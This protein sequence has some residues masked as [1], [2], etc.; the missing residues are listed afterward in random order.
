[1]DSGIRC[2]RRLFFERPIRVTAFERFQPLL[3]IG[4]WRRDR[5]KQHAARDENGES[6]H[7]ADPYRRRQEC[8]QLREGG[9]SMSRRRQVCRVR[10]SLPVYPDALNSDRL[11]AGNVALR[12]VADV[13]RLLRR[14]SQPMQE[15]L[16]CFRRRLAFAGLTA[17][18]NR[19][20]KSRAFGF[21]R[22]KRIP[23]VA[24]HGHGDPAFA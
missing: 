17:H 24:Q 10:L 3:V 5:R 16:E 2:E 8:K 11:R 20:A 19:S 14:T 21:A 4:R 18:Q 12:I 13:P 9:N 1:M 22:L 7:Y 6:A 23:S 15:Q